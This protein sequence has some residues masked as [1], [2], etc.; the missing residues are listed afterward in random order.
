[1]AAKIYPFSCI[2]TER[3]KSL[4]IIKQAASIASVPALLCY[5]GS[6]QECAE[7]GMML[8]YH[9]FTC[10]KETHEE[11][12]NSLVRAGFLVV[13]LDNVGHGERRYP[14]FAEIFSDERWVTEPEAAEADFLQIV[15]ETAQ[16]VPMIIDALLERGWARPDRLGIAGISMGGMISYAAIVIEPRLRVATPI[17][18]SPKWKLPW[19]DSPHLHADRFFPVALLSQT[20]AE[21]EMV[22][23]RFARTFH[24]QLTPL[25][26][27]APERLCYIE[28]PD[29]GHSLSPEVREAS[30]QKMVEWVQR[31]LRE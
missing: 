12:M 7:R 19:P 13:S 1:M 2:W 3:S 4:P 23:A 11:E 5:Q 10:T 29:V 28:Y 17:I 6:I 27:N 8:F 14:K 31:F 16:E 26:S 30:R 9:G 25:Y 21:D 15:R 22:P 18:G 24:E 20:G